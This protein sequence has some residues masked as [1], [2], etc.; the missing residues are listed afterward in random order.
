MNRVHDLEMGGMNRF[1][2]ERDQ[3]LAAIQRHKQSRATLPEDDND[4][5]AVAIE[6]ADMAL[7]QV[8]EQI[9]Q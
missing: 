1:K 3:L 8:A 4:D 9:P 6:D 7:Y 5:R 2:F